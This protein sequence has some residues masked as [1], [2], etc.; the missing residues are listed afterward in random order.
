MDGYE[1]AESPSNVDH[2]M[3]TG[4]QEPRLAVQSQG[5]QVVKAGGQLE[6][7][8]DCGVGG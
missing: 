3:T 7:E 5:M 4:Q 2:P 6:E 8:A 1:T